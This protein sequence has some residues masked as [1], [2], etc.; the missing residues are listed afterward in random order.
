MPEISWTRYKEW[1]SRPELEPGMRDELEACAD[2]PA[3][4]ETYFGKELVF[5]T[6]GIRGLTGPGLNR[7]NRYTVCRAT[8][9]LANYLNNGCS[10]AFSADHGT[11]ASSGEVPL[12]HRPQKRPC[13]V[14]I[15]YDTRRYSAEFAE[16]AALVLAANGIKALLFNAIRPTP[17]LSYA[18][19]ELGCDAGIVITAS[20]NP[21]DYNGYKVYGPDGGQAVSPLIDEVIEAI[22]PLNVFDSPKTMS[23]E[24]AEKADL[25]ELIGP[26][27]D[28]SYFEKVRGLSLS[29]PQER[30]TVVYTP[31]HGT[32]S[33]CIVKLLSG[34]GWADVVVV[35]EQADPDFDFSTVR[36]PNPE[37][38]AALEMALELAR[39]V[40]ADIVL[41]TDPD[42]D[43]V[44]TAVRGRDG[45]YQILT[46][47][48]VGAL[49]I[50]YICS[51]L[52]TQAA[53]PDNPVLVK[54]I[55][56]GELGSRVAESYGL[57]TVETLTG[58][59]FIGEKI[60]QFCASGSA[61]FVFGYEESCGYL[62]GTFVR[63]KDAAVASF[64]I[65]EMAA[66]YK[67]G[68]KTLLEVLEELHQRHGYYAED[69]LSVELQDISEADRYVAAFDHL[70]AEYAGQTVTAKRD[71]NQRRGW[72]YVSGRE[73]TLD[74]PRSR[75]LHY[76]LAD[77]SWFAVRPS[78]TE[79]KV[80]FYLGTSALTA[81]GANEQLARLRAEITSRQA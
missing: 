30:I 18:T 81:A 5:G 21:G 47:N 44:G 66:W 52:R 65:A 80:K 4:I 43:R 16:A 25:L 27:V 42:G 33:V 29:T 76:T 74:L 14:A 2:D 78:G 24:A 57:R 55:V 60:E 63:D 39:K 8:Q 12:G 40:E 6:G 7:I 15:A 20:H 48:Q 34:S 37:D 67:E 79:P 31:L 75:V 51:R 36:V 35:P 62:T 53:M 32:G 64:L 49:L 56:T 72:D 22:R 23:R 71:Y 17:M 41:A 13:R 26:E 9:G 59:K 1:L 45:D 19:R 3:M 50:E 73:Y 10:K 61:S 54:T 77:G 58:F 38:P 28:R 68:G 11:V 70:P 46:G 69:L